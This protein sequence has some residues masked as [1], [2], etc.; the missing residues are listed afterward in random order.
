MLVRGSA[1]SEPSSFRKLQTV[2]LQAIKSRAICF[3]HTTSWL[4]NIA[5]LCWAA[6]TALY[7]ASCSIQSHS[8][9]G[10]WP[11]FL[12]KDLEGQSIMHR[13]LA[14]CTNSWRS[15]YDACTL[16]AMHMIL[17]MFAAAHFCITIVPDTNCSRLL[18]IF[19]MLQKMLLTIHLCAFVLFPKIAPALFH[20]LNFPLQNS[21]L[22]AC[23]LFCQKKQLSVFS[24]N[25]RLPRA[26]RVFDLSGY[27]FHCPAA[28]SQALLPPPVTHL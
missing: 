10:P 4:L 20:F 16:V 1:G 17:H 2:R 18:F 27:I 28:L 8:R 13:A 7:K 14:G 24:C 26:S 3:L 25:F 15:N 11:F 5:T 22:P 6:D 12:H 21:C 9:A 23:I 19:C